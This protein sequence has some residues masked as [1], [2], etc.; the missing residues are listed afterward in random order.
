MRIQMNHKLFKGDELRGCLNIALNR[1]SG[2]QPQS[3][4][5]QRAPKAQQTKNNEAIPEETDKLGR[6]EPG[7][8]S[9]WIINPLLPLK[10]WRQLHLAT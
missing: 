3:P 10:M 9:S 4:G 7:L 8:P 2:F 1:K 6:S 5:V